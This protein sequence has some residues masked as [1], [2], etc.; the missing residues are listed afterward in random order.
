MSNPLLSEKKPVV[1]VLTVD[2]NDKLFRG[3]R[4]NFRDLVKTGQ[5]LEY[6]VYVVTAKDLKLGSKRVQGYFFHP[7]DKAWKKQWFPLPDVIYNRIPLREDEK[8]PEVRRKIDEV[9]QHESIHLFN[10][11]FFNK[12]RLFEWLKKGRST[13]TLVPDTKKMIGPKTLA[14]MLEKFGSLY[15]KPESGKAGKGIMLLRLD[16]NDIKPYRLTIQGKR[17]RN[18]VYKTAKLPLLWRRIKKEAGDT[19]YIMQESIELTSF[20]GRHFDMRVLVQKNG[21]G[22]WMVTG[23]GARLAGPKRITTHVPQGGSIE[24]PEKMLLPAFGPEMTAL[25]LSRIKSSALLIAKQIEKESSYLLG[26]MSMDLGVDTDGRLWFFEA[27][28][29]PMKFDEP[30]IRKKSLERIFQYSQYLSRQPKSKA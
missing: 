14:A 21:K 1:A 3:N 7:E 19:P 17:R 12:R 24:D 11:F 16:A 9:I 20:R 5:E 13:K 30:H 29:K 26:E 8:K 6:P 4:S 22:I 10:P 28:A 18:V 23:I 25:L 15:L 27:N 2:D